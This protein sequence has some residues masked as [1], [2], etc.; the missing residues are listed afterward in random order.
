MTEFEGIL[1][2]LNFAPGTG[3]VMLMPTS[4]GIYAEVHWPT[5]SLR[6]RESQSIRA[7]NLSHIRW[8][9]KHRQRTHNPKEASRQ[10]PIVDLAREWGS[11]GLEYYVISAHPRLADKALRVRCEMAL[12]QWAAQQTEF[13]NLNRQVG[14]RMA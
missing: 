14:Y 12:H 4:P 2:D 7:R 8:A 6:I 5:R 11:V 3:N 10:G 9:D 13:R 1:L